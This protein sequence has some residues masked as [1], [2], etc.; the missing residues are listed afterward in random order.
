MFDPPLT[1]VLVS[2]ETDLP[3][4]LTTRAVKWHHD[5]DVDPCV[6]LGW[7]ETEGT[8]CFDPLFGSVMY[9]ST[10]TDVFVGFRD[11]RGAAVLH[12]FSQQLC[13]L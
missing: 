8:W 2:S 12:I 3:D 13:S 7:V 1:Q 4:F 11:R 6:S 9:L 5:L 10:L